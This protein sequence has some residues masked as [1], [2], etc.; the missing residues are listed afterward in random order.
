MLLENIKKMRKKSYADR[1]RATLI[2]SVSLTVV[3]VFVWSTLI[4][5]KTLAVSSERESSRADMV[6]PLKTLSEDIGIIF[7]DIQKGATQLG[8]EIERIFDG[9]GDSKID[10]LEEATT[11]P[12]SRG[13]DPF[14]ELE[15]DLIEQGEFMGGLSESSEIPFEPIILEESGSVETQTELDIEGQNPF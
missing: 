3:I 5:P 14:F 6:T 1:Q 11:L 2:V 8:V 4:L 10:I 7:G 9:A 13:E 12:G 15:N